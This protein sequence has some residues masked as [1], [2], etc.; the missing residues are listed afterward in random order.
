M[1]KTINKSASKVVKA[2]KTKIAFGFVVR[3]A[4]F[5][6]LVLGLYLS[7]YSLCLANGEDGTGINIP[8]SRLASAPVA[9][10]KGATAVAESSFE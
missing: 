1:E 5:F 7:H 9:Q 10:L 4:A 2:N 8:L 3:K 6:A